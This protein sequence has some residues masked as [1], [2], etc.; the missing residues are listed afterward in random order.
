M[1]FFDEDH[2][3]ILSPEKIDCLITWR[4]MKVVAFHK[5]LNYDDSYFQGN[6]HPLLDKTSEENSSVSLMLRLNNICH[7]IAMLVEIEVYQERNLM[8]ENPDLIDRK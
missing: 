4:D 7:Q 2:V 1:V 5:S 8:Y 3:R 6:T